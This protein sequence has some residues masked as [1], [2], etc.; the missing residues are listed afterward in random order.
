[1][2]TF[3]VLTGLMMC[4]DGPY[5][6]AADQLR[7]L[8]SQAAEC[9]RQ[10][11]ALCRQWAVSEVL[12]AGQANAGKNA[13]QQL[14]CQV[15]TA[16]CRKLLASQALSLA[17]YL[18]PCPNLR[19][20]P[21]GRLSGV[22][23]RAS[24]AWLSCICAL[25]SWRACRR[26]T[27]RSSRGCTCRWAHG[28]CALLC[29]PANRQT[30]GAYAGDVQVV[31][32]VKQAMRS[33]QLSSVHQSPGVHTQPPA[34][35]FILLLSFPCLI[36]GVQLHRGAGGQLLPLWLALGGAAGA[37]AAAGGWA[38]SPKR[39]SGGPCTEECPAHA[40]HM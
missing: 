24:A 7:L 15:L 3:G 39:L 31:A 26:W 13:S 32:V 8:P 33:D 9:L 34:H 18:A 1:M 5:T 16:A 11:A 30:R 37:G 19:P 29:Q 27:S 20:Y 2:L 38:K 22:Q 17:P 6:S 35:T 25:P 36:A 28:V 40:L 14:P 21:A 4:W 10:W 12:L 23:R